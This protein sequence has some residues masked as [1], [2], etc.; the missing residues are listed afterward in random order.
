[1]ELMNFS[2]LLCAAITGIS[3]I[4]SLGFSVAAVRR[5]KGEARTL[6]LYA[7]ARSVALTVAAMASFILNSVGW[8]E[9][10]ACCMIIVQ[11]VDAVIGATI[12][13]KMKTFGPAS[14]AIF[15][16]ASLIWLHATAGGAS[17]GKFF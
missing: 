5:V 9:A 2:F 1:M 14:T 3:A 7:A 11:I 4:V 13:D 10:V 6:A 8:L 12:K 17:V 15:N 16:L